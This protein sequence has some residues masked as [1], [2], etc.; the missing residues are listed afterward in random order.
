MQCAI[1]LAAGLVL[2]GCAQV[3]KESVE[4]STTVGRDVT[5]VAKSHR[6][7]VK[8]LFARM[9][10]DVNR[11][12]DNVYVPYQ[13]RALME[14]DFRNAKSAAEDDRRA[15]LLLAINSSFQPGAAGGLQSDTFQAMAFLVSQIREDAESK[16]S[17][18]LA[19]IDAQEAAVL[20]AVDRSYAQITYGNSIVTGYLA[21]IVKVHD[22]QNEVLNAIGVDTDLTKLVGEKL[23]STSDEVGKLVDKAQKVQA[24][25]ASVAAELSSLKKLVSK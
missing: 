17:E 10:Q 5:T 25:G 15:S 14:N 8:L 4:L 23:A 9:R 21:S 20:A 24:T 18:L 6:A 3:P 7:L 2:A 19:P 16:R 13:I 22:A 12:V 11:F 1:L